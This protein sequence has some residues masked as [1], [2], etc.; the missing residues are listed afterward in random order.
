V[1][2]AVSLDPDAASL[3]EAGRAIVTA[4]LCAVP[5]RARAAAE[6]A[7]E[8]M[9][10]AEAAPEAMAAT[11]AAPEAM[12]AAAA[13]PEAMAA[14]MEAM[15][16]ATDHESTVAVV[17]HPA[18]TDH[19]WMYRPLRGLARSAVRALDKTATEPAE[20]QAAAGKTE[21]EAGGMARDAMSLIEEAAESHRHVVWDV[22]GF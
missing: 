22:D 9:A 16:A 17:E 21:A 5:R 19:G 13:A 8:A 12:A 6:A 4:P 3:T 10:A 14:A 18:A 1:S 20:D 11:A 7:L 15:A 2:I